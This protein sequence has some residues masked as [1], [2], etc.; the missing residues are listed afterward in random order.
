MTPE[1]E[2]WLAVRAWQRE[3]RLELSASAAARYP[4]ERRVAG[5]TLLAGPGWIPAAPAELGTVRLHDAG[6]A[7]GADRPGQELWAQALAA[8]LPG[9]QYRSYSA[10]VAALA[11][12]ATFENR[13]TYQLTAA[14][15]AGEPGLTF[16]RGR[17]FDY[18]DIGEACA[19]EHAAAALGHLAGEPL[20]ELAGLPWELARRGGA[21]MAVAALTLRVDPGRGTADFPLHWRDPARVSHAGGLYM[22][23]P[24]GVF[25]PASDEPGRDATDF[26]LWRCLLREF[27]E[28]LL[29]AP[30]AAVD[31]AAWPFGTRL[32]AARAAGSV[33]AWVLGL[34]ADPL[35]LAVDLLAVVA[36]DAPVFDEL[37]GAVV[38]GNAEGRVL[39]ARPFTAEVVERLTGQEPMQ[40][41][42]AALLRLAWSHRE[43]ILG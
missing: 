17:Y 36:V 28:E 43:A 2:R 13:R 12:P 10:A 23:L 7:G 35:T 16:G 9:P 29:G 20:R 21:T 25:Q 42:G 8:V 31:Y 5:T 39:A 33:R 18:V 1:D 4:A 22:V 11:P 37:F 30:E 3:H 27:A 32:T 34:G 41:A 40:P 6:A 38:A 26:D 14:R 15:L 19:H 24:V